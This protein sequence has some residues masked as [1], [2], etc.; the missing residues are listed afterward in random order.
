MSQTGRDPRTG[1]PVREPESIQSPAEP[2]RPLSAEEDLNAPP[3]VGGSWG[4][5]YSG[6]LLV[7]ILLILTFWLFT[8][9]YA[10]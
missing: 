7:L 10:P 5:L 8:R 4:R 9:G 3:P 6:V 2:P 1:D